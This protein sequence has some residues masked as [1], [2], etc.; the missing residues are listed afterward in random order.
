M[1]SLDNWVTL[2]QCVQWYSHE[3]AACRRALSDLRWMAGV[4][5]N[6]KEQVSWCED[7]TNK[8]LS[9]NKQRA[10][11]EPHEVINEFP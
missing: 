11:S 4:A 2:T 8:V 1:D 9:R 5:A 7:V 3:A 6:E 10:V